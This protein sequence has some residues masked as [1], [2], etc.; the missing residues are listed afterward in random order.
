VCARLDAAGLPLTR[1]AVSSNLLD[2][3]LD[4]RSVLWKRE[5][6]A[7]EEFYPRESDPASEEEW[8]K[9]PFY[10]LLQAKES[11]LRRRLDATYQRG[12]FP[13]LDTLQGKGCTD[14]VA[15]AVAVDESARFGDSE[16]VIS[17]WTTDAPEG[18]SDGD[19]ALIAA[20]MPAIAL[21]FTLRTVHRTA[22][23]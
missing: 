8:V 2:P 3:T 11:M 15:V 16:G 10:R 23:T 19:L 17:S 4:A 1:V 6:G 20:I 21:A 18:Y 22:R 13:L 14:Y 9:S 5:S 12:E 7:T